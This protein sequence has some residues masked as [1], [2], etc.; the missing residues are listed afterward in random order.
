M[1]LF[2]FS[3]LPIAIAHFSE[4]WYYDNVFS[5]ERAYKILVQMGK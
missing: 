4:Q 2:F 5:E 3:P 1:V